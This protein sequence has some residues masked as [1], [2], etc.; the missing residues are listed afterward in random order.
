V[1]NVDFLLGG[2]PGAGGED[3][4]KV[5]ERYRKILLI[6]AHGYHPYFHKDKGYTH[7]FTFGVG[8]YTFMDA[9]FSFFRDN[10]Y[11]DPSPRVIAIW[12]D[13]TKI[14]HDVVNYIK[15]KSGGL[16]VVSEAFPSGTTDFSTAIAS[17][18]KASPPRRAYRVVW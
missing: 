5:A 7:V 12:H 3:S 8:T 1:H 13:D 14:A 15:G 16:T 10:P 6:G 18:I 2:T 11:L 4:F 17:G 9:I